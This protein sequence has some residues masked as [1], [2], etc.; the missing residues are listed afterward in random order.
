MHP[1]L[2]EGRGVTVLDAHESRHSRLLAIRLVTHRPDYSSASEPSSPG[3]ALPSGLRN[4][5]DFRRV[6]TGFVRIALFAMSSAGIWYQRRNTA[7]RQSS[8]SRGHFMRA[9]GTYK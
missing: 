4:G 9:R 8:I 6:P 7:G 2:G 3:Y 5:E 1:P